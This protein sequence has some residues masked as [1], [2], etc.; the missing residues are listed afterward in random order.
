MKLPIVL[1]AIVA[2]ALCVTS[3]AQAASR[4]DLSTI[5]CK[6]FLSSEKDNI[7]LILMWLAGYYSDEDAPPIVDFDKMKTDGQKLGE[8]CG[9]HPDD[10]LITASEEVMGK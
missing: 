10:S 1:A 8:Y 4:L 9:K 2:A 6:E 5:K 7:A 3:P